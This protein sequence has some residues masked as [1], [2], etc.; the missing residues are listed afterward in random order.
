M[1]DRVLNTPPY[2]PL[3]NENNKIFCSSDSYKENNNHTKASFILYFA[4]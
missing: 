4:L 2:Y 1:F 3:Q